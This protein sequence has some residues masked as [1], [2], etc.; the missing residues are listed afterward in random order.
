MQV[1]DCVVI[2]GFRCQMWSQE[3]TT[4]CKILNTVYKLLHMVSNIIVYLFQALRFLGHIRL[5]SGN[6]GVVSDHG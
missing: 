1:Y 5:I 4:T 3:T 6:E 2:V